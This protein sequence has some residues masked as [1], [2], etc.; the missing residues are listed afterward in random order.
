MDR[1]REIGTESM[2]KPI[3]EWCRAYNATSHDFVRKQYADEQRGRK[4]VAKCF[5]Q[6]MRK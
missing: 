5:M 1:W 2:P 6:V 4:P 3:R